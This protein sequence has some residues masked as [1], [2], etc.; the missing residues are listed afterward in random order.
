MSRAHTRTGA[1]ARARRRQQDVF[2]TWLAS[3]DGH[4]DV[5]V[6]IV[7]WNT[8]DLLRNC[9]E[10]L[11]QVMASLRVETIVV[12]NASTDGSV[13]MVE[14]D[15]PQVRLFVNGWNRGFAA[16]NNQA[17]VQARGRYMLLLNSDTVVQ[18]GAI[19]GM[20]RF[21]DA[22]PRTG[23]AGPR[24]L[25]ADRSLQSSARDFNRLSYDAGDI[26]KLERWP[27]I[28]RF[29]ARRGR[30]TLVAWSD[31]REIREVDWLVGACLMLRRGML[32][33]VGLLDEGY[34]F[35]AEELDLCYRL[36]RCGW[37]VVLFPDAEVIHY[38]G[39][40][41]S[42]VPAARLVW[43]YA[44]LL[45]FYALHRS[46]AQQLALRAIVVLAMLLHIVWLLLRHRGS[47]L[48]R[49]LFAAYMRVLARALAG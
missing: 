19:E 38:G 30:D 11:Q 40:S 2:S 24:L 49:P 28:G 22:H 8:K 36:R 42:R 12:D 1:R 15:F 25:N 21:M 20:T 44:G 48:A 33:Q 10:P 31:H 4:T 34:F 6:V 16:A 13:A 26:L 46:L 14:Q 43:H 32:I 9:L 7:N 3:W 5:S 27:L 47:S 35:F 18:P 37:S 23:L 29:A 39:Q 17:L 45:R 41:A